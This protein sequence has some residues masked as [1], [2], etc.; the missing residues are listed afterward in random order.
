MEL[1]L[2]IIAAILFIAFLG[3]ILVFAALI[4]AIAIPIA[5]VVA[6]LIGIALLLQHIGIDP[7]RAFLFAT[8]SA[9]MVWGPWYLWNDWKKSR[10]VKEKVH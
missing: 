5:I 7:G 9:L 4:F 2:W 10:S 3:D 1:A 8:A 6:I